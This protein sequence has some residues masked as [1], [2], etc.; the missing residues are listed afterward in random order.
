M[1]SG[2]AEMS[3]PS[4]SRITFG[5]RP[6]MLLAS[7]NSTFFMENQPPTSNAINIAK[8]VNPA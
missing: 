7:L 5:F 2:S 1:S 3:N 8:P 4:R 6:W